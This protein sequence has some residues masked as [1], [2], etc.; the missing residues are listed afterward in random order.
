MIRDKECKNVTERE[1]KVYNARKV[2]L[3]TNSGFFYKEIL[4]LLKVNF[5][6]YVT[7]KKPKTTSEDQSFNLK[8][9]VNIA[10]L[11]SIRWDCLYS[12]YSRSISLITN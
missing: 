7:F 3:K 12:I 8:K 1:K 10:Y 4:W 5:L 2:K 9:E 6:F 11:L